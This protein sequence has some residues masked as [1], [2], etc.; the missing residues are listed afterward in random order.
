MHTTARVSLSHFAC[1]VCL[2]FALFCFVS[3]MRKLRD[4]LPLQINV[5]KSK[6]YWAARVLSRVFEG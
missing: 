1:F 3:F 6:F 5:Q 4:N 2:F